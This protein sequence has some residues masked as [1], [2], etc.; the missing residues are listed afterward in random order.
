MTG[1][2]VSHHKATRTALTMKFIQHSAMRRVFL[3]LIVLFNLFYRTE[4][5]N[6]QNQSAL[7][8]PSLEPRSQIPPLLTT[9]GFESANLSSTDIITHLQVS[10][11]ALSRPA[12]T[13]VPLTPSTDALPTGP[14][15]TRVPTTST[16]ALIIF[17]TLS[18]S[19]P[20]STSLPRNNNT[21]GEQL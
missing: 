13:R 21:K 11:D 12:I 10:T 8:T 6:S 5:Q 16:D 4:S 2:V 1:I 7:T 19:T 20:S 3:F 18:R 14:A 17:R 9:A 15:I